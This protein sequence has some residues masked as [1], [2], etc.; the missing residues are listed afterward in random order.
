MPGSVMQLL[1]VN[2]R[3]KG[4]LVLLWV[5][6]SNFLLF[7]G[8]TLNPLAVGEQFR[9]RMQLTSL[10]DPSNPD[11][12]ALNGNFELFLQE[13]EQIAKTR[14]KFNS[15]EEYEVSMVEIF[16]YLRVKY[17][18]D[19]MQYLAIDHRPTVSEVMRTGVDDCDGRAILAATLLLFRG[20]DAWV[21]AG[22]WHHWVQVILGNGSSLQILEKKGIGMDIWY[23]RFNDL[24]VVFNYVQTIGYVF[25]KGFN[26]FLIVAFCFYSHKYLQVPFIRQAARILLF[27]AIGSLVL[28]IMAFMIVFLLYR[29][30][31]GV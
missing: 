1:K 4:T 22:P 24:V 12:G 10:L 2:L 3:K 15:L 29:I 11:I 28:Y 17:K 19:L 26:A 18:T 23:L 16:T 13:S 27:V 9:R 30:I 7:F 5:L 25:Y 6:L 20:Y 14:D 31:L 21:L 8:G